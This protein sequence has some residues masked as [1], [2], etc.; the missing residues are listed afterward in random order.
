VQDPAAAL[1][2]SRGIAEKIRLATERTSLLGPLQAPP[3]FTLPGGV[4]VNRTAVAVGA[5][6]AT[7]AL[8][9]VLYLMF[10]GD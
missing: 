8:G 6:A 7:L 3:M 10:G 1:Y 5:G 4:P 2:Q 9:T